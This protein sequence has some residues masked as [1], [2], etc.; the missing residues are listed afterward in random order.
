[1]VTF[2][3]LGKGQQVEDSR[4]DSEQQ[5]GVDRGLWTLDIRERVDK[6]TANGRLYTRQ[7]TMDSRLWKADYG[8]WT[9]QWTADSRLDCGQRTEDNE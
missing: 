7:R 9:G 1:M 8:H 2:Y 6:S 3:S 5:T 4:L